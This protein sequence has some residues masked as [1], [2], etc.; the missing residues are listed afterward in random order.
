MGME[1]VS[2][3]LEEQ[4]LMQNVIWIM[5]CTFLIFFMQAGFAALET[6]FG[7]KK[8]A[9]NIMLKNLLTT[10]IGTIV[11]YLVGYG[12]M[13]GTDASGIVGTS[14][15]FHAADLGENGSFHGMPSGVFL[16]YQSAFC[17]TAATIVSGAIVGRTKLVSYIVFCIFLSIF[18]YPVV[19]HWVWGGGLLES[20]GFHDFAG[21][22]A[23]HSVGGWCALIGAKMVGPR[24]GKYRRNGTS[25]PIP[26]HNIPIAAIGVFILWFCWFGFNCG[27]TG[28][29]S[30]KVGDIAVNTNLAAAASTLAA[31]LLTKIRYGK[32]DITMTLNGTLAGLVAVTGGCD[33]ISHEA[34]LA[35]GVIAGIC[36][37]LA[38][39][40]IDKVMKIDDPVGA[41]SV[42]LVCGVVGSVL[43]AL[44]AKADALEMMG[45]TRGALV[46]TQ[47]FGVVVV[48]LYT[49]IMA[50]V[51]FRVIDKLIGLRVKDKIE[52]EGLDIHE[53]GMNAYVD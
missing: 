15:L 23:V 21:S 32:P 18:I 12:L 48:A 42:H 3:L 8:N 29:A 30:V 40:F 11:F 46:K 41:T 52:I 13:Y 9:G 16:F 33:I 45:M 44:F 25:R 24:L 28:E 49:A 22:T 35:V 36:S 6:G 19:G 14:G 7:R 4:A 34:A 51:A 20:R 17:A 5:I 31:L 53:H 1:N 10:A 43:T 47:I 2:K 39:E 37:A 27:S 38:V 50:Y 26:G